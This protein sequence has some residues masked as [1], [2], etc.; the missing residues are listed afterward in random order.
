M[1][2][3]A[4]AEWEAHQKDQAQRML[5]KATY[6]GDM[7]TLQDLFSKNLS[8]FSGAE[9]T[10]SQ[11]SRLLPDDEMA[12]DPGYQQ[13]AESVTPDEISA[14]MALAQ[15]PKSL[16]KRVGREA[17][18]FGKLGQAARAYQLLMEDGFEL[19]IDDLMEAGHRSV[20]AGKVGEAARFYAAAASFQSAPSP[21][22]GRSQQVDPILSL[23]L[24]Q[25]T[26]KKIVH[27]KCLEGPSVCIT[28]A[29]VEE[30]VQT[31]L[32]YLLGRREV[33]AA[34]EE[35]RGEVAVEVAQ[36]W[37]L[38]HRKAILR[39]LAALRDYDL[40][41]VVANYQKALDV[42]SDE[43]IHRLERPAKVQ[44]ALLGRPPK[45]ER[46]EDFMGE[47]A[48]EHP[49]SMLLVCVRREG[50]RMYVVPALSQEQTPLTEY[51]GLTT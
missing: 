18:R 19:A 25:V 48:A 20:E 46:A 32:D 44:E 37:D 35:A 47:L 28:R 34:E 26:W 27:P 50:A 22:P 45:G 43:S 33:A 2:E 16:L 23:P 21:K 51:L 14:V 7:G 13:A 40:A 15:I 24:Y 10:P 12:D 39:E 36:R 31:G 30:L 17:L 6:L 8:P 9:L 1:R 42:M 5:A 11:L 38:D 4:L 49:V 3:P 29:P 41:A